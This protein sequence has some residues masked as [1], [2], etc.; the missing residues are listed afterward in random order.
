MLSALSL[1][2]FFDHANDEPYAVFRPAQF[3]IQ[4]GLGTTTLLSFIVW[5]I[6]CVCLLRRTPHAFALGSAAALWTAIHVLALGACI[7][8]YQDDLKRFA[9]GGPRY[10]PSYTP[11]SAS[12]AR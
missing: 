9:P 12:R 2:I 3:A 11:S 10:D 7:H 5:T 1:C 8:G 4:V 6:A